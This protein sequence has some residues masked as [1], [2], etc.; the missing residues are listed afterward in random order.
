MVLNGEDF[1]TFSCLFP[2]ISAD[3]G[4]ARH[5]R[6]PALFTTCALLSRGWV[7]A[8]GSS[9]DPPGADRRWSH[10]FARSISCGKSVAGEIRVAWFH[11]WHDTRLSVLPLDLLYRDLEKLSAALL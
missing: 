1:Q 2:A 8:L 4:E 6:L 5:T 3:V 7:G 9:G 10:F 11:L